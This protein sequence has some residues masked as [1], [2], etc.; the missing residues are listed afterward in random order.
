[1]LGQ[2]SSDGQLSQ[3]SEVLYRFQPLNDPRWR[4][5]LQRH[6]R[7][8]VFHTVQWL[9][10]LHRTYGY[11][12]IAISTCPPGCDLQNAAVFCRVESWLTGRRLVSLPFS[13]HCDFLVN[14]ADDLDAIVSALAKVPLRENLRYVE[15]RPTRPEDIVHIGSHSTR[16]YCLHEIDLS[17]SV[18][19]LFRNCHKDSTQRKIQRA[20]REGLGYEEGRSLFL[21]E[22]FYRLLL[23]TRRRHLIPP[24]PKRWFQNLIDSF[25]EALKIRV[26]FRQ[27][28]PIAAILTLRYKGSLVYKYGCSNAEFHNL[29]GMHLL[30]WKSILEAKQ[31]GLR[32]FDLGRSE[33][34]DYGLITFKDRWGAKRSRLTYLRFLGAAQSKGAFVRSDTDWKERVAKKMFRHLPDRLL[35]GAGDL[36]YR[37]IG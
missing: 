36:I 8:S 3:A 16:S 9:E 23:L 6:P 10:A 17:P 19:T 4:E 1:M 11:E 2:R 29:G 30:L 14:I 27:T 28:I 20:E 24:Q 5:F 12:P 37:H 32:V 26:A 22:S 35:S 21:L 18:G 15:I 7:S 31:D 33:W 25:G 13:D 34:G